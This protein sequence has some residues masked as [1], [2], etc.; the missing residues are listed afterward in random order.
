MHAKSSR[1]VRAG[2]NDTS[3]GAAFGIGADD[4]RFS[5][6]LGMVQ[7]LDGRV[8]RIHVDV[9]NRPHGDSL[10][11][12]HHL[13]TVCSDFASEIFEGDVVQ[14]GRDGSVEIAPDRLEVANAFPVAVVGKIA[15]VQAGE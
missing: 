12:V 4:D 10:Y 6:V 9:K 8:K 5:F 7:L 15:R 3:P 1:F 11:V 13:S 2:G 14:D